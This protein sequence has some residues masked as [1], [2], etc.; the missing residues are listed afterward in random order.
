MNQRIEIYFHLFLI[1]YV[2]FAIDSPA[3]SNFRNPAIIDMDDGLPSNYI[4]A[5]AKDGDG[6]MWFGTDQGLCRWDGI[7]AVTFTHDRSDSNS[8]PNDL[9]G[10]GALFW[11]NKSNKL[12]IGTENGLSIYNPVTGIFKNLYPG[13]KDPVASGNIVSAIIKDRQG[14]F[15]IA[16]DNGFVRFDYEKREF[17]NHYYK[18]EFNATQLADTLRINTTLAL[19][20]DLVNDSIIWIG[21]LIVFV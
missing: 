15:W 12:F 1:S 20:Q 8:V 13:E 11:D 19:S 7:S 18:G 4:T 14:I 16:T 9:I 17:K 2:L 10:P 3:Q 5:I 6:F 21:T